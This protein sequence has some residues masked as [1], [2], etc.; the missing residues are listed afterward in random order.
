MP[1]EEQK[2]KKDCE[3]LKFFTK[4][5]YLELCLLP[6]I[7]DDLVQIQIIEAKTI[8]SK[9]NGELHLN[10]NLGHYDFDFIINELVQV[11]VYLKSI[12][13][14]YSLIPENKTYRIY[15]LYSTMANFLGN[16]KV[17][18]ASNSISINLLRSFG[19]GLTEVEK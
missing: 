2:L 7:S 17:T 16:E 6:A 1:Q 3:Q 9:S 19:G 15:Y 11:G 14:L 10:Q 13:K 5:L 4:Q 18:E 12:L 8:L